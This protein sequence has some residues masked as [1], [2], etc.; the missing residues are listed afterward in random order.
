MNAQ[1]ALL[2]VRDLRIVFDGRRSPLTALDGVH[3]RIRDGLPKSRDSAALRCPE[4]LLD[5]ELHLVRSR[6]CHCAHWACPLAVTRR[7]V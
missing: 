3:E 6:R 1:P 4:V 2:S 7:G 5:E